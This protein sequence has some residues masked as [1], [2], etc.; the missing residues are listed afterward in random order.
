MYVGCEFYLG[1]C[2]VCFQV[3]PTHAPHLWLLCADQLGWEKGWGGGGNLHFFKAP[4][5]VMLT[6]PVGAASEERS[7]S[8]G[9][10]KYMNS[11]NLS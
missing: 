5:V 8:H 2:T 9:E 3:L 1:T 11:P 4:C 10:N 6:R 7:F